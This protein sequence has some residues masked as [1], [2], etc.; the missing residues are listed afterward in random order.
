MKLLLKTTGLLIALA[1]ITS[2]ASAGR[3]IPLCAGPVTMAIDAD[4]VFLRCVR[5]GEH[6]VLRAINAP[7]RDQNWSTV[8]PKN[9]KVDDGGDHFRVTFDVRCAQADIDFRCKRSITGTAKGVLEFTFQHS[10]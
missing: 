2:T 5:V 6:E 9:L 8:A 1:L 10:N 3:P 7:I 4:N